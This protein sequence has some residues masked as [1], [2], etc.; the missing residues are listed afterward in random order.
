MKF[1]SFYRKYNLC[2]F[3]LIIFSSGNINK[4][5]SIQKNASTWINNVLLQYIA[6]ISTQ[7]KAHADG[8]TL[9]TENRT[10]TSLN[11]AIW[12]YQSEKGI[13]LKN[14][15]FVYRFIYYLNPPNNNLCLVSIKSSI[16]HTFHGWMHFCVF[17]RTGGLNLCG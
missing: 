9:F 8:I 5:N 2:T 13:E 4:V 11:Y 3:N 17:N 1:Q 15:F 10:H 6:Y 16:T 14:V 7:R 12:F